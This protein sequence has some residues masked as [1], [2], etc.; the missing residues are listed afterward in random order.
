MLTEIKKDELSDIIILAIFATIC[1]AE[2]CIRLKSLARQRLFSEKCFSNYL[3][4][5][6]RT[7]QQTEKNNEITFFLTLVT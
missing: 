5:F 2:S 7:I 6:L 4:V 3:I 1:G